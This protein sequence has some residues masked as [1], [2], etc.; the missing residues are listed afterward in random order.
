MNKTERIRKAQDAGCR[1]DYC[2]VCRRCTDHW[3]EHDDEQLL[4]WANSP[5][6]RILM[7]EE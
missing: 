3:G 4:A 5:L 1:E 7:G 6:G 2:H